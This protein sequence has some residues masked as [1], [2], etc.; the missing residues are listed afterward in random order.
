MLWMGDVAR[1]VAEELAGDSVGPGNAEAAAP[2]T[3]SG[4]G[5]AG[6]GA[7]AGPGKRDGGALAYIERLFDGWSFAETEHKTLTGPA[8]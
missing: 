2:A 4:W 3:G 5:G 6:V 8:S 1:C 7:G